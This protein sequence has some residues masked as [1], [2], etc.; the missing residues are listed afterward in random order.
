L[1]ARAA[2]FPI[3]ARDAAEARRRR[4]LVFWMHLQQPMAR[5]IGRRQHGLTPWRRRGRVQGATADHASLWSET[6]HA[7]E[8]WVAR[9]EAALQSRGA[10]V[11]RGGETDTWDLELRG[12]LLGALRAR[13]AVEEHGAGRQL[14]R[15][16]TRGRSSRWAHGIGAAA[17]A[18]AAGAAASAAWVAAGVLALAAALWTARAAADRR[19]ARVL[20]AQ[21]VADVHQ[22]LAAEH[23]PAADAAR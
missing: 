9:V 21:A 2:S 22:G 12:G 15:L 20:W 11:R 10:V 19:F 4:L 14:L 8:D 18:L 16:A 1:A 17:A 7:P 5:L 23:A 3:P 13:F 6:W